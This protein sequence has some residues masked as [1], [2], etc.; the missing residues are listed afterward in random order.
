M[1]CRKN[2]QL[3]VLPYAR[4]TKKRL[5]EIL[6]VEMSSLR[7]LTE[8]YVS[9]DVSVKEMEMGYLKQMLGC[10]LRLLSFV[11]K[12]KVIEKSNCR[13]VAQ[14]GEGI[15][16]VG[17]RLR[18]Y[19][20]IFGVLSF[21]RPAYNSDQ[22]GIIYV[23]DE[24]LELPPQYWS[25]NIQDL[26][27]SSS[28]TVNFRESVRLLNSLLGLNLSGTG[29]ERNTTHLGQQVEAY[30]E[31]KP[32]IQPLGPVHFSASFDGKGVPIKVPKDKTKPREIKRLNAGEK[33]GQ[34]RMSTVGVMSYFEPKQRT[35]SSVIEGLMKHHSSK[36][37]SN[38]KASCTE[39]DANPLREQNDN[40]WHQ[41]IHRRAFMADQ[42]KSV[43]YGIK[44]IA[45][46]I[47]HP[48]SRFV[49]PIDAGIGLEDKVIKYVEKYGLEKHFDGII[50]DIIHVSEYIWDC[51]NAVLGKKC[52][53]R[54]YWVKQMLE[55]IL[56]SRT[57]KVIE[58]LQKIVDKTKLSDAKM[59][60][61][62]TAIT[63]FTN[64]K[65]KM[66][67]KTF[68][69]KGYPVSSALVE[70]NCGYFVKHRMEG[71]GRRWTENGAQDM[72]DLRAVYLN[73]DFEDFMKFKTQQDRKLELKKIKRAA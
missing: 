67:Y 31:Q 52:D 37:P 2:Y 65:H 58:D 55:D 8:N 27:G 60:K 14:S 64:H 54:S 73:E 25:Y 49:V 26:V 9:E 72:L 62:N 21:E 12:Q 38:Q 13:P 59:E 17:S 35:V 43:E 39:Q 45:S 20:S 16:S 44:Y 24:I 3:K 19:L 46:M 6:E 32:A 18:Q 23:V 33:N 40:R 36:K 57:D 53:T 51:A 28:T 61:I 48:D 10:C 29:S 15:R 11:I 4:Y 1:N 41:G 22:R 56:H 7:S 63:Y 50:L 34:K 68:I 42:D 71:N 30:Y 66:D 70:S 5:I 47:S 69:E